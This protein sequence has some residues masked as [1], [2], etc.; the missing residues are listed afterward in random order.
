[1]TEG[2]V[3][4]SL[5]VTASVTENATLLYQWYTNTS[6]S[7][8]GGTA[9]S[10]ATSATY[11]LPTT[12]AAG[13]YYYFC[14]ITAEDATAVRTAAV[15][16]TVSAK[17]VPAI[18]IG[19]QPTAPAELTEGEIPADTKLTVEATATEG[20]TLAYQWHTYDPEADE[21]FEAIEGATSAS[22]TLPATL[23]VGTYYYVCEITAEGAAAVQTDPVKVT[24][25]GKLPDPTHTIEAS[26]AAVLQFGSLETGYTQ[27]AAQ[28]VTI[29][30][31][32]TGTVTL[33]QPT[34]TGYVIGTLSKTEITA[35]ATATFTVQPKA[36]LTAGTY[37]ETITI[38]GSGNTKAT[39]SAQFTVKA[40]SEGG[41]DTHIIS[42]SALTSF[43]S[44]ETGYTQPAAQTV[45]I[46]NSGTGTVTLTQPTSTNYTIGALSNTELAAGATATFT[47]QP[48]AGLAAGTYNETITVSGSGGAK[49]T[50]S[51]QFTVTA[52]SEGGD[53]THIISASALTSFGSLETGYT[54]PAAQTVTITNTGTGA[55]TLAQPTSTNYTI[56]S[57]S[58]TEIAAGATAT[59]TVQPKAGL[60]A[61]TYNETIT[62]SGSGG[63]KAT[64]SAQFTVTAPSGGPVKITPAA[65]VG[66][67][68]PVTG[69]EPD[70]DI[71]A[72]DQYTA[73]IVWMDSNSTPHTG[74]FAA[75]EVYRAMI[76]LTA[77]P[78]YTFE[79]LT[80]E[81][82]EAG[83]TVNGITPGA[84]TGDTEI[85]VNVYFPATEGNTGP[86]KI[87]PAAIAGV[88][89]P[90]AGAAAQSSVPD[91][92]QYTTVIEWTS[93]YGGTFTGTAFAAG[94]VYRLQIVMN[95]KPGYTFAGLTADDLKGFTV[96]GIAPSS[97][98]PFSDTKAVVQVTFPAT[99]KALVTPGTITGVTTPVA[100]GTPDMTA[101]A[102]DQYTAEVT[103]MKSSGITHTGPFENRTIYRVMLILT[104]KA[105]YTFEG[106]TEEQIKAG[107]KVNGITPYKVQTG[108][109]FILVYVEFPEIG[110]PA[111]TLITPGQI[112]GVTTPATG[113]MPDL[114]ID[115][116]DAY[117]ATIAWQLV[118][119]TP[120]TVPFA[121]G[122][123]YEAKIVLTAKPGYTFSEL[124][125][126]DIR[127]KF[128]VNGVN[129]QSATPGNTEITFTVFFPATGTSGDNDIDYGREEEEEWP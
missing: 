94:T 41:D 61:G 56:G 76:K 100:G 121:A 80:S 85:I 52:P 118:D 34:A 60:S 112:T 24:V 17:P 37:N 103:W 93:D 119:D 102:T 62:V 122:T 81:Q 50:V 38:N 66:V 44:L 128:S 8:T 125:Y 47:V 2:N 74:P 53:D 98:N 4:G 14:E 49:A 7:N 26:P 72:T 123:V 40:P 108:N 20:V 6:A 54:Q 39:V 89:N 109:T 19:K 43:G 83:F 10:G 27:P 18:T 35:G 120:H 110:A 111:E 29:T 88:T 69:A 78:G 31:T 45:T 115:D 59:F 22:Y 15:T 95:A 21:L 64:V 70:M 46:T 1:M 96:N 71:P 5:S 124:T 91:T 68:S 129:P 75:G 48:K 33:A 113:D 77:K 99:G 106:L 65:I 11:T 42:A 12:L 127:G 63:A 9:I 82:I 51:A 3:T 97:T 86:V 92:D 16:V 105:D 87:T 73:V 25:V 79:G 30:N 107:F 67:T 84:G 126:N 28:T 32:G 117:T 58:N 57:L 23:A 104:A 116:T 90:V 55:V 114:T 13:T 36:G 101:D